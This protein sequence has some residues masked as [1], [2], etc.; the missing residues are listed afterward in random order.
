M[1]SNTPKFTLDYLENTYIDL[2]SLEN[3]Y[4]KDHP[5]D[6]NLFSFSKSQFYNHILKVFFP[7]KD[8]HFNQITLKHKY[9]MKDL[10]T[11]VNTDSNEEL[12]RNVFIKCS[13]L[14]NPLKFLIGKYVDDSSIKYLPNLQENETINKKLLDKNNISYIDNFFSFLCSK[15]L[16]QHNFINGI[17]YYGYFLGIQNK[18]KTNISDDLE[19]LYSHSYFTDN[20][21]KTFDI[22]NLQ[23]QNIFSYGSRANKDKLVFSDEIVHNVSAHSLPEITFDEINTENTGQTVYE[24]NK[25]NEEQEDTSDDESSSDDSEVV[26]SDDDDEESDGEGHEEESGDETDDSDEN[27]ESETPEENTYAYIPNYPTQSICLEKCDGTFDQL[28]ENELVNEENGA[29]YLMQIIMTLL[30]LQKAYWFTHNDLHTN[31]IMY[32]ETDIEYIYYQYNAKIYKIPTFGKIFKLIDFGRAIYKFEN[33]VFCSDSFAPGDDAATQYNFEPYYNK[34]KPLIE[35]NMSFDLCRLGCS[36]YDFMIEIDDDKSKF[37]TFQKTIDR[38]CT[39]DYGKNVLYKKNGEERYPD[40]KLY[41][42]IARSVHN[43][44]PQDQLDDPYFSQFLCSTTN[45]PTINIDSIMPYFY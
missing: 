20:M 42:M 21:N 15:L 13:P 4:K 29:A 3:K 7:L 6:Y 23:Y 36:I 41:K 45:E 16:H 17:D 37:N 43:H 12:K 26:N 10:E 5:F 1:T 39:D 44:L 9:V 18:F 25:P 11:V 33:H 19:F 40:F 24:L 32:I 8:D 27:S 2:P 30:V 22:E 38:W 31:N 28:L 35:P 14:V 34:S